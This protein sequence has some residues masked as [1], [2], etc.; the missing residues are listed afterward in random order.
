MKILLS[1]Y[2]CTPQDAGLEESAGWMWAI[3][4]ARA[5][6]DITVLTHARIRPAIEAW[7]EA[8]R[9][10]TISFRYVAMFGGRNWLLHLFWQVAA[11][12]ALL[13]SGEWRDY[14]LIHHVTPW[15][16]RR[17]SFLWLLPRPFAIGPIIRCG[18]AA[19]LRLLGAAGPAAVAVE[20][21]RR[22]YAALSLLD[23]IFVAMQ[24]RAVRVLCQTR[25]ARAALWPAFRAKADVGIGI[26]ALPAVPIAGGR[27]PG[28]ARVLFADRLV[29][30][31][32]GHIFV[33]VAAELESRGRRYAMTLAGEGPEV[34]KLQQRAQR[35]RHGT[36]TLTGTPDDPLP[37]YANTDIFVSTALRDGTGYGVLEAMS[38][39]VPIVCLDLGALPLIVGDAGVV[40]ATAGKDCQEVVRDLADAVVRLAENPQLRTEMARRSR[41]RA[42]SWTWA[43]AVQTGSTAILN[44][45]RE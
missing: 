39:G 17:W 23:P 5:G 4:G 7:L 1:A 15:S 11:L 18:E 34:R 25:D 3:L 40:V 14:D 28:P 27:S 26:V 41:E 22:V 30:A 44:A 8:N 37:A 2:S 19:P 13:R 36:L 32:G 43:R 24:A 9:E 42:A 20:L 29:A 21:L 12:V 10:V 6:R 31:T 38:H 16:I 33:D 45:V 35:L